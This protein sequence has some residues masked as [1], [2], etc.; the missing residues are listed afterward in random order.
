MLASL[1][2]SV[3]FILL[4]ILGASVGAFINWAI[5]TWA[6]FQQRSISPWSTPS[7]N[8]SART[9]LDRIPL[10]GWV[11]RRRD[12]AIHGRGFWI[13]PLLIE[14][15]TIIGLPWF[16]Q[17]LSQGGLTNDFIPPAG[18]AETWFWGQGIL[19]TLMLIGTFIDFDEKTIPDQVTVTGTLIALLF[20]ALTPWF[21]LP[22]LIAGL[23]GTTIEPIHFSS[24][25]K[26]G[27]WHLGWNGALVCTLIFTIWIWALLPK[28]P[29]WYV[30]WRKSIR[31]MFA[32]ALQPKRKTT[33]SIRTKQRS[34]PGITLL[35]GVL[36]FVGVI[37]I[38]VAWNALPAVNLESLFG[39][40]I[41][42]AFGG[43]M[44]WLIRILGT[45]AMR[46]EAMGF[47]DVT[48]MAMIGAFLGWQAAFLAFVFSPFAAL[49]VV[50]VQ[51]VVTKQG[52]IA[53][54]PYLCAGALAVIV[55]WSS[56]W[57]GAAN[58]MFMLGPVLIYILLGGLVLMAVSLAVITWVKTLLYGDE[59]E[60]GEN[61]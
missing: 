48:L 33:C 7:E 43:G 27:T 11:S 34:L 29:V 30:G 26:L 25:N 37:G 59:M 39:S 9:W 40:F 42:L 12:S 16:Y 49:L 35:L 23:G 20:A 17:W 52:A 28:L 19:L 24:P 45:I 22:Q 21:R 1:P 6:M 50:I 58:G 3:R 53:F 8:E 55:M 36:W 60:S 10:I 56:I 46:Q 14:A 38:V 15:T 54:G 2:N 18:L 31:F 47:G 61:A 13:R 51:F 57:P 41:G 44:I 5:Y 32:H 4:M